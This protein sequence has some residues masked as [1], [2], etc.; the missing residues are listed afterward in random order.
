MKAFNFLNT[1]FLVMMVGFFM[2]EAVAA[3]SLE[4]A[5]WELFTN[6]STILALEVSTDGN[7]Q[8]V[9]TIGGL[10]ERDAQTGEL[11]RVFTNLDGLPDNY[12][13]SLANDDQGGL[14]IG[15][16][17]GGLANMS[18][19][20]QWTIF[21]TDDTQ[22]LSNTVLSLLNNNRGGVWIG[23]ADAGLAFLSNTGQWRLFNTK[24]SKLPHNHVNT[25]LS[26]G[27]GGIWIGTG[28]GVAHLSQSEQWQ[29]FD[30]DNSA[31]PYNQVRTM[32]SDGKGGLW[33][34]T[35]HLTADGDEGSIVYGGLTHLDNKGDGTVFNTENSA[36]PDD[37][38]F[39]LA[40]DN[41]NGLWIGT[42]KGLAYKN[43]SDKWQT[44]DQNNSPL[45]A[46]FVAVLYQNQADNQL[47]VGT[48]NG[49][50]NF[51][52]ATNQW[53]V[54]NDSNAQL[55]DTFVQAFADDDNGG[56][57]IG[58]AYGGLTHFNALG[59]W[60]TFN[61]E[62]SDLPLN[63]VNALLS[64][65]NG[66][67]WIGT[68]GGGLAQRRSAG[69]WKHYSQLNSDLPHNKI[70]QLADDGKGGL[71]IATDGGG[72]AHLDSSAQWRSFDKDNSPLPDNDVNAV[73]PDNQGGIWIATNDGVAYLSPDEQ[74]EV[75]QTA[76]SQLPAQ[77]VY[78]LAD[79]GQ[80][81]V[82]IGTK[83]GGLAHLNQKRQWDVFN[84]QN[85]Q[86]PN[87]IVIDLIK[88]PE[89]GLW[90]ATF[91]GLAYRSTTNEWVIFNLAN[92]G[93][94][95]HNILDILSDGNNGLWIAMLWG[96]GFAHL[97]FGNPLEGKRAAI[98]IH[99][100]VATGR[101]RK[102]DVNKN[103][104]GHIYRALSER[105]YTNSEI[106]FL[107]YDIVDTGGDKIA[108][109]DKHVRD[110]PNER[111]FITATDV[112]EAMLWAGK[113]GKLNEPLLIVMV[114]ELSKG[115]FILDADNPEGTL[116]VS[117][118]KGWLNDYQTLTDNQVI[119]VLE[120]SQSGQLISEL[121]SDENRIIITS[122]DETQAT[123]HQQESQA[124]TWDYFNN[125]R[126]GDNF[127]DAYQNLSN[128]LQHPIFFDNRQ[129]GRLAKKI[130]LNG[131]Y[132]P[133]PN[134]TT[135]KNGDLFKVALDANLLAHQGKERYVAIMLPDGTLFMLTDLNQISPFTGDTSLPAWQGGEA[136]LDLP[137]ITP[138]LPRGEYQLLL[139][140]VK[141]GVAP[142]AHPEFWELNKNTFNI[143]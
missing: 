29:L 131:C 124:F 79:D 97:T 105:Y 14:W 117:N 60:E 102:H 122:T 7:T 31:L 91:G 43:V 37:A 101:S 10:E 92:S 48:D 3:I 32:L 115:Q 30:A 132:A 61:Q 116:N 138:D 139:L 107:S 86:L 13:W 96:G 121:A 51:Q 123:Q 65:G 71:W 128:S 17:E 141:K 95:N 111:Y 109:N 135:Y 134:K 100:K 87:D 136:V 119:L 88:V 74:W 18:A 2:Q 36:L 125:L 55:P 23:T 46:N 9:G 113:Q 8:W 120:A 28:N 67:L 66:G 21:N 126:R 4:N 99:P 69:T 84:T 34:S 11:K 42:R 108:C 47:W 58:T 98:V 49:L 16:R 39:A 63:D 50:S 80:G 41:K 22:L 44:F 75:F 93:L 110:A 73:L 143:E 27:Q 24:N 114:A 133:R 89:G 68:Y 140:Q 77:K 52:M 129:D 57:W 20:G 112:Q 5:N 106:Y 19:E 82:W 90:I 26:D 137:Q 83:E 70:N 33:V 40:R 59:E 104:I 56:L 127:W 25:L 15:T 72:F 45:P 6:R 94:P 85:S 35:Y 103:L 64:D 118:F 76:N 12:I 1:T 62:N 54:F 142:L 53:Q 38:I 78:A 81:G 130:C